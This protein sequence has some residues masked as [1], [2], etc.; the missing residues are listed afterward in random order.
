MKMDE[1]FIPRKFKKKKKK[2]NR[3]KNRRFKAKLNHMK[4]KVQTEISKDR[5][6]YYKKKYWKV[7]QQIIEEI[8][9][10]CPTETQQF[11]ST[12]LEGN[13]K[14]E[15]SPDKLWNINLKEKTTQNNISHKVKP[16]N[17]QGNE[18]IIIKEADNGSPE[19]ILNKT[20]YRTK[21]QEILID[22]TNYESIDTNIDN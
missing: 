8:R 6:T 22:E 15:K 3:L 9:K 14:G 21:T 7:E 19:V 11:L 17:I 12:L 5:T 10:I 13:Y 1:I 16:K 18:N 20:Y 4:L 2:D